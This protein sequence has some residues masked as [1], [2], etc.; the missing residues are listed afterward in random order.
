[1]Q[2][3]WK[4]QAVQPQTFGELVR[5]WRGDRI[6]KEAGEACDVSGSALSRIEGGDFPDL[7]TFIKLVDA[8]GVDPDFALY[9]VRAQLPAA[10][11]QPATE[12]AAGAA[13]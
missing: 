12:Q 1:M 3:C 13:G 6:L 2:K 9:L 7:R 8:I 5:G 4:C 10:T 11:E